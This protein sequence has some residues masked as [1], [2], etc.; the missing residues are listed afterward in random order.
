MRRI[1]P[2]ATAILLLTATAAHPAE[3][4]VA[5]GDEVEAVYKAYVARLER[6]HSFLTDNLKADA[7]DLLPLLKPEAAAPV[8]YGY[9]LLPKLLP[10]GPPPAPAARPRA[11]IRSYHWPWTGLMIGREA[12]KLDA[13]EAALAKARTAPLPEKR[14]AYAKLATDYTGLTSGQALIDTHI[15]YNRLWQPLIGTNRAL[16]DRQ[17]ALVNAV[18][19]RQ[20]IED[21]W[22]AP[23][24]KNDPV[25]KK[26][27]EDLSKDIHDATDEVVPPPGLIS[28][29]HPSPRLWIV[30]VPFVTDIE[31]DKFVQ[32]FRSAVEDAW[33]IRDDA[34]EYRV[35]LAIKRVAPAALYGSVAPPKTGD[36]ITDMNAHFILFPQD[37]AVLTTGGS[38]THVTAARCIVIGTNEIRP[39]DLAHEFGHI[40]GFKDVYF[41][42]YR[43]L[44]NDGFDV[45][46]IIAAFD[47]IMGWGG[48]R[49]GHFTRLIQTLGAKD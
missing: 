49:K 9:Q 36:P 37:A 6:Y 35:E 24:K 47:D 30:R 29:S 21:A 43:D 25:L 3:P 20:G 40:L 33:R 31:D 19:E 22:A 16:Y 45:R 48:V 18:V 2:L 38:T 11:E 34:D 1:R 41:R 46:E 32:A 28:V 5:R 12:D 42:G 27:W 39:H 23:D 10:D 44:G 15:Q 7:P 17:T 14:A 4:W 8:P 13:A 26:R